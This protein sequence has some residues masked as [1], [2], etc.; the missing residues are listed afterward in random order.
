M[1]NI[2]QRETVPSSNSGPS[3][4]RQDEKH[5]SVSDAEFRKFWNLDNFA[6]GDGDG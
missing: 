3:W 4:L 1:D 6:E 2:G 5:G